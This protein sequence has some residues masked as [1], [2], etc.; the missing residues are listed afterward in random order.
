MEMNYIERSGRKYP[1][2]Y[3]KPPNLSKTDRKVQIPRSGKRVLFIDTSNQLWI[4]CQN[5]WWTYP[6][7]F[8]I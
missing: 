4:K 5:A 6:Q 2:G 7:S 3:N 1:I 8:D